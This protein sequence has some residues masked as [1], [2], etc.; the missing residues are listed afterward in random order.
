MHPVVVNKLR[1]VSSSPDHSTCHSSAGN[2]CRMWVTRVCSSMVL[3]VVG[4]CSGCGH[5]QAESGDSASSNDSVPS[6]YF[7][8]AVLNLG[9]VALDDGEVMPVSF[10]FE[11]R[12]QAPLTIREIA[13]SCSCTNATV[14]QKVTP[15][16]ATGD[17]HVQI[18]RSQLGPGSAKLIIYSDDPMNPKLELKC[19]WHG[20]ARLQFDQTTIDF[21]DVLP[22]AT[23]EREVGLTFQD[24]KRYP[25]CRPV[26][27]VCPPELQVTP[28]RAAVLNEPLPGE[29]RYLVV[30]SASRQL[31]LGRGAIR[32]R[33]QDCF[34]DEFTIP[35]SWTVRSRI[36]ATPQQ[37][38]LD[39]GRPGV[40][41]RK[42]VVITATDPD[43][44]EIQSATLR[45]EQAGTITL[46]RISET[47]QNV[48]VT[49]SLTTE[50]QTLNG[51]IV[52][53]CL[54]PVRETVEI[55]WSAAKLPALKKDN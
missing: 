13:S 25:K 54:R 3:L 31:G 37:L 4:L 14:S 17:I 26:E 45:P 20:I 53:E 48:E 35:V 41:L 47:C 22:G 34:K 49:V 38:Y 46:T 52:L 27:I 24:Q 16:G 40:T 7:A 28:G 51:T 18:R 39:A 36:Q 21:G 9:D 30:L 19:Q 2:V 6:I 15:P 44:L 50:P 55:P 1:Y 23:V 33:F 43:V 10:R 5:S 42:K 12:G 29:S 8:E 11:N 32:F